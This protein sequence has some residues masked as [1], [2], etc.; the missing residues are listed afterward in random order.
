[1]PVVEPN[2]TVP[3]LFASLGVWACPCAHPRILFHG[4]TL[5]KLCTVRVLGPG[6]AARC[7]HSDNRKPRRRSRP[8]PNATLTWGNQK[9]IDHR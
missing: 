8:A 4:L 3:S 1:V 9:A 7:G 2:A 5:C 6:R